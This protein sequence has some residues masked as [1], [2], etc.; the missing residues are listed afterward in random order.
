LT[1]PATSDRQPPEPLAGG[2]DVFVTKFNSAGTALVPDFLGGIDEVRRSGPGDRRRRGGR[3][4]CHR[5][6][7]FVAFDIQRPIFYA[8]QV[9]AFVSKFDGAGELLYSTLLGGNNA[10]VGNGI[11][12]D[13]AGAFYVAGLTLSDNFPVVDPLQPAMHGY[14][15]PF[16]TRFNPDGTTL[17]N[18]TYLGGGTSGREEYGFAGIALG[19]Q[20]T[21]TWSARAAPPFPT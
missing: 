13:G 7:R 12:V 6:H 8:G 10:D 19:G 4:L 15:D 17:N 5:L 11:A 21:A 14:E 16:L 1:T 3:S 18:S 2:W 9:D 20:G